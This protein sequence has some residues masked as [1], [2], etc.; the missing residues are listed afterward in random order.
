MLLLCNG[1]NLTLKLC[2]HQSLSSCAAAHGRD[3]ELV[4]EAQHLSE[5]VCAVGEELAAHVGTEAVSNEGGKVVGGLEDAHFYNLIVLRPFP[6]GK[7][8]T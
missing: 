8:A 2:F 7:E 6:G 3:V 4:D 1:H 5:L